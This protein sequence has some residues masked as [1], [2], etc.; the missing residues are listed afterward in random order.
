MSLIQSEPTAAAFRPH[1]VDVDPQEVL[2]SLSAHVAVLDATGT[3][4]AVNRAWRTCFA[5]KVEGRAC[6]LEDGDDR[7][8][9]AGAGIGV[10]YL[11]VCRNT[12]GREEPFAQAALR[13]LE[14][15]L[16]RRVPEFIFSYSCAWPV[17]QRRFVMSVTPTSSPKGGAIVAHYDLTDSTEIPWPPRSTK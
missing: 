11:E 12:R 7:E 4:V 1:A 9:P 5:H 2:D 13:G 16:A 10:N 15:V 8:A 17:K 14:A 6:V 3:I